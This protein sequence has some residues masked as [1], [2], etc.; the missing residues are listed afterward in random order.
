MTKGHDVGLKNSILEY[1]PHEEF[2]FLFH[3]LYNPV[4]KQT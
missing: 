3:T 2:C 4:G 1:L